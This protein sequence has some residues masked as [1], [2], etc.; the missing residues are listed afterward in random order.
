MVPFFLF[1][2]VVIAWGLFDQ[3]IT[4]FVLIVCFVLAL[5]CALIR[6]KRNANDRLGY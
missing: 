3:P 2:F 1:W 6:P 5:A 4:P